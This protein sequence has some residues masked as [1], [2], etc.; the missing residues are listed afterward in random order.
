MGASR[1][2]RA[3]ARRRTSRGAPGSPPDDERSEV[4]LVSPADTHLRSG[5]HLAAGPRLVRRPAGLPP[6]PGRMVDKR[7]QLALIIVIVVD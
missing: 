1:G 6:L 4:S 5:A 3:T 7:Q 2:A